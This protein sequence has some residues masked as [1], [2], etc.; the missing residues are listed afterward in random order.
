VWSP[1]TAIAAQEPD[2]QENWH[3]RLVDCF[4]AFDPGYERL[5]PA[6]TKVSFPLFAGILAIWANGRIQPIGVIHFQRGSMQELGKRKADF[7]YCSALAYKH[8]IAIGRLEL[9]LKI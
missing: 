3:P 8:C 6:K 4:E 2:S 7:E 5:L 1:P 9:N